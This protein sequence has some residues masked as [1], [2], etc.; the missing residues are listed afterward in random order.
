MN[1]K[2]VA[3]QLY[4]VREFLKTPADIA[5][6]LQ[7]IRAI[8]Y[9]AVQVSGMGPIPAAELMRM[10]RGEGLTCC[11]THENGT[12]ILDAPHSIVERL[13]ELDCRI[14]AYPFPAGIDLTT[15]AAVEA[16]A[17]KLNAA[18]KVLH[19]AGQVLCYHNHHMELR[20][21]GGRS[22]LE[23]IYAA[24]DPR[25]LQGEPD[26]Y[27]LQYGGGDPA[28]W[29]I[30]LAGRLPILHIKDYAINAQ[31]QP[32]FSEIGNGNL[33]WSRIIAAADAAGCQW[34]A[35]EQDTCPGD[36]FASLRQSFDYIRTNLCQ[37]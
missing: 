35:V 8:G 12:E 28:Q 13:H 24:T 19:D 30:R 14:T 7:K 15:L 21:I 20:R 18:G 1:I 29:C 31:N 26:T 17:N 32:V 10:L 37:A 5:A 36:P 27:W 33:N 11:A 3:V 9:E 22:V 23:I 2:Q 16:F 6:S 4:T 34:Y 25:C